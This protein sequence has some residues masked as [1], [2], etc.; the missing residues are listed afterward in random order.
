MKTFKYALLAEPV[1]EVKVFCQNLSQFSVLLCC[2]LNGRLVLI[3][4]C[5]LR[6]PKV[7]STYFFCVLPSNQYNSCG[8]FFITTQFYFIMVF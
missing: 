7:G 4:L 3:V 2:L 5:L 1:P 6:Q 8:S